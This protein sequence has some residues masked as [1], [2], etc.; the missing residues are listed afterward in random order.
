[1]K[2]LLSIL[3]AVGSLFV[4]SGQTMAADSEFVNM[5]SQNEQRLMENLEQH[6]KQQEQLQNRHQ[7]QNQYK[8]QNQHQWN[9]ASLKPY[10]NNFKGGSGAGFGKGS[11]RGH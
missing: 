11:G 3:T 1:M 4:I 2:T 7:Y 10:G 6:Y 8:H 9:N 5:Q